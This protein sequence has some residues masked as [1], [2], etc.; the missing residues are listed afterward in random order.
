LELFDD[1]VR[2]D[3][4]PSRYTEGR[5]AFLNRAAGKPFDEVR[6]VAESWFAKYPASGRT[7]LR[8]R[9]RSKQRRETNAAWWELYLHEAFRRLG[10]R[11]TLHPEVANTTRRPDF[12]VNASVGSFYLEI[13]FVG[14]SQ[15]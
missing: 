14:R 2:T 15:G 4:S 3:G 5:F 11:I 1:V 7:D 12:L 8:A 9:F 6:L 10:A 13:T